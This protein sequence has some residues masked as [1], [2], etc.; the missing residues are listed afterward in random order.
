MAHN[1]LAATVTALMNGHGAT[2]CGH[3]T[4]RRSPHIGIRPVAD[5]MSS[6]NAIASSIPGM[7]DASSA[8]MPALPESST[9]PDSISIEG[10]I[11]MAA[12]LGKPLTAVGFLL[13]F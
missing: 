13:N 12:R 9:S 11:S 5:F 1:Q 4:S 6:A 7:A 3:G 10:S 8:T 2:D